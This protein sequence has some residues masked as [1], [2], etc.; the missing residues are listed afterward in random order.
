MLCGI[1]PAYLN[2][3]FVELRNEC[4]RKTLNLVAVSSPFSILQSCDSIHPL[5]KCSGIKTGIPD[6]CAFHVNT[7]AREV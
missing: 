2:T 3:R 4:Q 5:F 6:T 1:F 7:I